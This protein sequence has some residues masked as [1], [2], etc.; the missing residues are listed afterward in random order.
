MIHTTFIS[1]K[2]YRRLLNI[3]SID[4]YIRYG[5]TLRVGEPEFDTIIDDDASFKDDESTRKY[6]DAAISKNI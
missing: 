5:G 1:Y 6:I 3:D 2:E 4:K